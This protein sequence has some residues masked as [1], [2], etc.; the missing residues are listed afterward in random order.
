MHHPIRAFIFFLAVAASIAG[1]LS[2]ITG[3]PRARLN[4][5]Q[6]IWL[7]FIF[8]LAALL[9]SRRREAVVTSGSNHPIGTVFQTDANLKKWIWIGLALILGFSVYWSALDLGFLSDDFAHVRY[10][11]GPASSRLWSEL[12]EGQAKTFF[13]P[14]GFATLFLDYRLWSEWPEGYHLSNLML[15]LISVAGVFL[16]CGCLGLSWREAGIG[17]SVFAV[18]PV[19]VEAVGWI[20]AR[21][22]LMATAL[23]VW[24]MVL[25]ASFRRRRRAGFYFGSLLCFLAALL[26]K[27][28][29]FI[30]PFVVALYEWLGFGSHSIE[31]IAVFARQDS[32]QTKESN[33]RI[34]PEYRQG[35]RSSANRQKGTGVIPVAGFAVVALIVFLYRWKILGGIGGYPASTGGPATLDI[36]WRTAF[37][38]LVRAPAQMLF[39]CNWQQPAGIGIVLITS[40]TAGILLL[41]PL[42]TE[43]S[44]LHK[45]VMLLGIGWIF[46]TLL[47]AHPLLMIGSGLTNSRILYPGSIGMALLLA[48]LVGA[49]PNARRQIIVAPALLFALCSGTFHNLQ[50]WQW[51]NAALNN[52]I[53]K[54]PQ[55]CGVIPRNAEIQTIGFPATLRGIHFF[56]PELRGEILKFAL[57]REDIKVKQ[58]A[59][60]NAGVVLKWVNADPPRVE[61]EPLR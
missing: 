3:T 48:A 32:V 39:A 60:G 49:L 41:L 1:T 43:P 61:C 27:E 9:A 22:D 29:A 57:R 15:H 6:I 8:A 40:V 33:L 36:G 20:A 10:A 28:C 18:L 24:A 59:V 5:Q 16:L 17:A 21:F 12:T 58:D 26:S 23:M 37:A 31:G 54:L 50:A 7:L 47:P 14:L 56:A 45:R 38:L 11:R 25:Y 19:Q 30:F 13:R 35:K 55:I 34:A 46:L 52:T 2:F 51:T 53:A 42:V 44:V 4:V